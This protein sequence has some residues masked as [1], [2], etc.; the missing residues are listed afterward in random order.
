MILTVSDAE[1]AH[2]NIHAKH[3]PESTEEQK[4]RKEGEIL[5]SKTSTQFSKKEAENLG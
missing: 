3:F 4:W 2:C 1:P 5:C